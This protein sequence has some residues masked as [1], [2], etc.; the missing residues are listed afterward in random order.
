MSRIEV[1]KETFAPLADCSFSDAESGFSRDLL[2]GMCNDDVSTI[3]SGDV[4]NLCFGSDLYEKLGLAQIETVCQN[5]RSVA[6]LLQHIREQLERP[7][8]TLKECIAPNMFDDVVRGPVKTGKDLVK[9]ERNDS[10]Q[11]Q[12]RTH[13]LALKS[14][15]NFKS[16]ASIKLGCAIKNQDLVAG[17]QATD[18]LD[19]YE[20]ER[21]RKISKCALYNL[22]Q[23]QTKNKAQLL[24]LAKDFVTLQQYQTQQMTCITFWIRDMSYSD[25]KTYVVP[26]NSL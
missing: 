20:L 13:S 7:S 8:V 23:R 9:T 6:R 18:F 12:Q 2:A 17:K 21:Q 16:C 26:C 14:G 25:D 3:I 15:Y 22:G 10:C 5:M 1:Q 19:S 11:T 4:Y 24:P